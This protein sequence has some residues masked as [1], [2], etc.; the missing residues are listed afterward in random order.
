MYQTLTTWLA[1]CLL[2][3]AAPAGAGNTLVVG[4]MPYQGARALITE[5]RDLAAHL[6][7]A[8][9]RPVRIV[10]A[11]NTRVFGQRLLAG[12]YDLALAPAHFARLTQREA[13]GHL[14]AENRPNTPVYLM[15]KGDTHASKAPR[16]GSTLAVPDRG[17]LVTLAAQHWLAKHASLSPGDYRLM[18]AGSHSAALQAVLNGEAD[19]AVTA[20]AALRQIR[21]G[22]IER[23]RIA[24]DIGTVPLLV[25]VARHNLPP[26]TR[27]QLKS[28]LLN[29]PVPSPLR[30]VPSHQKNLA[31]MDVYL[32]ATRQLLTQ[33]EESARVR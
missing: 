9:K 2:V 5:H 26:D 17:L 22:Q 6:Q 15:I 28:A 30:I 4:V 10:T 19:Y 3:I 23:L 13:G 1:L 21:P 18:E 32:P 25:Y 27:N 29:F 8:L 7:A 33:S 20:L 11:R 31:A 24:H 16:K 12:D 14:L